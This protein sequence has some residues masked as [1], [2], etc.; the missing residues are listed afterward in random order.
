MVNSGHDIRQ[1]KD[2]RNFSCKRCG[3]VSDT[4]DDKSFR[5]GCAAD[6]FENRIDPSHKMQFKP[7]SNRPDS[8]D[9]RVC[10]K[11]GKTSMRVDSMFAT[12][13]K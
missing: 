12:P 3:L 5:A 6:R 1:T 8:N 13:C 11:C 10:T 9:I 4:R 7:N 2:G